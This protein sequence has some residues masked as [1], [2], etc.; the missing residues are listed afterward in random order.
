MKKMLLFCLLSLPVACILASHPNPA[1]SATL[2]QEGKAHLKVATVYALLA[3]AA[4][5]DG[6]PTS[7]LSLSNSARCFVAWTALVSAGDQAVQA[8]SKILKASCSTR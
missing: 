8:A 5:P 2:M 3:Y 4:F 6:A 7:H 1:H